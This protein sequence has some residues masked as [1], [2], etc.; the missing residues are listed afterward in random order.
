MHFFVCFPRWVCV[1]DSQSDCSKHNQ[2]SAFPCTFSL[3]PVCLA[4]AI[5]AIAPPGGCRPVKIY[6]VATS[7]LRQQSSNRGKKVA[8]YSLE[9]T[10]MFI[11]RTLIQSVTNKTVLR[12]CYFAEGLTTRQAPVKSIHDNDGD[13][14][15]I[16][17]LIQ[18]LV[19]QPAPKWMR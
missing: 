12:N 7:Y 2:T 6:R 11:T 19:R 4:L 5:P 18:L 14:L 8:A 1:H 13:T 10:V 15:D 16:K 3:P 9:I 17:R